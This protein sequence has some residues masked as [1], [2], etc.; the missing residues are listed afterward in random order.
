M[1]VTPEKLC[2]ICAM[3]SLG[4]EML[5]AQLCA[6]F[7]GLTPKMQT[8][9]L[10]VSSHPPMCCSITVSVSNLLSLQLC[11]QITLPQK[12]IDTTVLVFSGYLYLT[13]E[14]HCHPTSSQEEQC[15]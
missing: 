14:W 2:E 6:V 13:T 11:V 9:L 5:S 15:T 1:Q 4:T 12:P 10:S 7:L 8:I 3:S